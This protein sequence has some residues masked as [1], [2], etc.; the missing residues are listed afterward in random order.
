[1]TSHVGVLTYLPLLLSVNVN[2]HYPVSYLVIYFPA[3]IIRITHQNKL[4]CYMKCDFW[5]SIKVHGCW[6]LCTIVLSS[7][8]N[9]VNVFER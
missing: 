9:E 6:D 8:F 2:A 4:N 5:P 3:V 7:V 1:M